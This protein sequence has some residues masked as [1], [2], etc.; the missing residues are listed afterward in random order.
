MPTR[1]RKAEPA[2]AAAFISIKKQLPLKISE[3]G[4]TTGGFL[5]GNSEETYRLYIEHALCLVAE[6]DETVV[7]FGIVFP[8][9]LVR[10]SEI[11]QKRDLVKWKIDIDEWSDK[12]VCYFEQLAFL[13]GQKVL[14][15]A[16]ALQ[17][18][19]LAFQDHE[20][21]LTTTVRRPVLNDA[22]HPFIFRAG[23]RL[24]GNIDEHYPDAGPINSDIFILEK[25]E[26]LASVGKLRENR[27]GA[28]TRR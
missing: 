10:G 3:E 11:W 27:E 20:A 24:A 25:K 1:I 13:P 22:A 17:L 6:K 9:P 23:G 5:L 19:R 28:E 8:D 18:A 14:P 16:L 15:A 2:D 26:F 21:M 7:G 4:V 12:P